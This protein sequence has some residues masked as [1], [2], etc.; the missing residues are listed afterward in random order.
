MQYDRDIVRLS[1]PIPKSILS[2]KIEK[3]WCDIWK[4]SL[5]MNHLSLVLKQHFELVL[6][7]TPRTRLLQSEA[8]MYCY[9]CPAMLPTIR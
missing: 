4:I 9:A 3:L 8:M 2:D 5:P 1:R 6:L 7:P